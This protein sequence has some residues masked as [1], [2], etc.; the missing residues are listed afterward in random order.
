MFLH[1]AKKSGLDPFANQ[2]YF[3]KRKGKATIQT[4][5]DGYRLSA[6]RS[7]E[8]GGSDDPVF[9]EKDGKPVKA[10]VTI[11]RFV[12]GEKCAF[13]A[14][15][16]WDEYKPENAFMWN[17]MPFTMLGKCAEALALRKA[18]PQ[19]LSG[20]YTKE[21]MDQA[22]EGDNHPVQIPQNQ[23]PEAQV[24]AKQAE[25]IIEPKKEQEAQESNPEVK[26]EPAMSR[27]GQMMAEAR[28]RV[29]DPENLP[30]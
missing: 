1:V 16:R 27:A 7:G 15:A 2:I 14:S 25:V 30:N 12:K 13:T 26:N 17:K 28:D 6:S 10:T 21:E 8:Y 3:V 19:E 22:G 29:I 9:E 24:E 23:A 11:Y 4:G 20:I 5:I 18:F